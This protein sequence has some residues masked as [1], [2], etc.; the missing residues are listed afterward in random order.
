MTT[1]YEL[2]GEELSAAVAEA[3]GRHKRR[4][5]SE[6]REWYW[7]DDKGVELHS[8]VYYR[9]D[10]DIWKA[11]DLDGE[12]WLWSQDTNSEEIEVTVEVDSVWYTA[13]AK[14]ED[15]STRARAYATARCRAYL[16][17]MTQ[18]ATVRDGSE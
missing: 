5:N 15:H 18:P 2:E 13:K 16:K 10:R 4:D 14:Y 9:P 1:I 11:W 17:A 6:Y 7:V 12:G 3:Q 8:V